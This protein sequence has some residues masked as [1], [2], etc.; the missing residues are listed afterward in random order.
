MALQPVPLEKF[1]RLLNHGPTVMVSAKHG[2]VENV[3]SAAWS[4]VLDFYPNP[5]VT[6]VLDK[7]AYTRGLVEGSGYFALQVPFANQAATVIAMGQSRKDNPNKLA[8]NG[9]ELFYFDDADIPLVKGC[10]AYILC[11]L[12]PEPHNQQTHDLFIGQVI[13]AY[14]DDRVFRNGHWEFD[15]VGD[16]LKNL[17]YVAGG[18][19]YITGKGVNVKSD[20]PF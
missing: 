19:F 20:L 2:G 8:D 12:I 7:A 18:Q 11:K 5:K 4:C 17:H 1:Y 3:M 9:V 15:E 10:S 16:E 14:A 6:V 13:A